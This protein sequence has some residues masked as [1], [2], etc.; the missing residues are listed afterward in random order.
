MHYPYK[1]FIC[2]LGELSEFR[3][4]GIQQKVMAEQQNKRQ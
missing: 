4:K 3:Q 1:S 2:E